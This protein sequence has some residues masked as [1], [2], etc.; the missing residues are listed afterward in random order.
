[1]IETFKNA[2]KIPELRAKLIFTFIII[3]L[4]RIGSAIPVPYIN[5]SQMAEL[6]ATQGDT[7]FGYLNILSGNAFSQA[8]LFALGI[9]PYITASIIMQLLTVAIPALER[10]QKS[11]DDGRK[12]ITQITR[13]VTVVLGLIT[14]Y[15]Y[16]I[17]CRSLMLVTNTSFF[18]GIV[19]VACYSAGS[20]L[21]MWLGEK[22]NEDGIGNGISIILFT[23]IIS[24]LPNTV[25]ATV[26]T[27]IQ[28]A[29]G[30]GNP[31]A[32]VILEVVKSAVILAFALGMVAFVVFMSNAERR[33][34]VQYS[35]RVVG[36]KMYGGQSTHLPIKV[37]MSGVMPIIFA[38]SIVSVPITI[39]SFMQNDPAPGTTLRF[40]YD[41]FRPTSIL[42][43]VLTF[44]L[45]IAFSYFYISISFNPIEVANNLK[46]NGGFIPGIRPGKP[47][48]DYI[49]KIL[50]KIVLIGGLFLAFI[51]VLPLTVSAI[52]SAVP[53]LQSA[54][55]GGLAF[56]GSSL[57]IVVGV[58]LE[59]T[60]EIEAQ[61]SMR[62]YK[63]FLE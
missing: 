36:R 17:Y 33:L 55:L 45:I 60:R 59:T 57:L 61:M 42:Y 13:Y 50:N 56:G 18:V 23:N 54:G 39:I 22:I 5:S 19:I 30:S 52:A 44:A 63:G 48:T 28:R 24:M 58:A 11:G 51:A 53:I 43:I 4:Y 1:M 10:M 15:G 29:T 26:N 62:H 20:A 37:N 3:I 21:I 9:Q 38:S 35:K 47:T 49:T 8:T 41:L 31:A 34:Q 40:V 6:F 46:K 2:F 12:K 25:M 32:D 16:Y 7:I 27:I 14:G